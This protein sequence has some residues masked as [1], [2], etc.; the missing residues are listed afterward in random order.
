MEGIKVKKHANKKPQSKKGRKKSE[1][2]TSQPKRPKGEE[3]FEVTREVIFSDSYG[4]DEDWREFLRT[5]KPHESHPN[6]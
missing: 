3:E 4:T 6:A 2:S 5:H 1:A